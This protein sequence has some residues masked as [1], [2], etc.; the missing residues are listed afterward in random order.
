VNQTTS[1]LP[2]ALQ[3]VTQQINEFER[4]YNRE[5]DSVSLLAVS[6][7]KPVSAIQTAIQAGQRSFGEN[8]VDE[9]IEKI[10]TLTS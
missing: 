1:S 9:R 4:K 2:I 6:K 7:R 8:Y 10:L 5:P 3:Q